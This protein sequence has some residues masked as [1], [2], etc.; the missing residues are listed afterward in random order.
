MPQLDCDVHNLASGAPIADAEFILTGRPVTAAEGD[1]AYIGFIG[2]QGRLDSDGEAVLDV[3]ASPDGAWLVFRVPALGADFEFRMPDHDTTLSAAWLAYDPA[4]RTQYE[5]GPEGPPGPQGP[6]PP[7]IVQGAQYSDTEPAAPTDATYT[8]NAGRVVSIDR[9]TGWGDPTGTIPGDT[10]HDLWLYEAVVNP[11]A[12]DGLHTLTTGPVI[13][14]TGTGGTGPAGPKGDK[15]DKGDA[16]TRGSLW[17]FGEPPFDVPGALMLDKLLQPTNGDVYSYDGSAWNRIG[18]IRGPVGPPPALSDV[19]PHAPGNANPGTSTEAARGDHRHPTPA[20]YPWARITG[21]PTIPDTSTLTAAVMRNTDAIT[22]ITASNWVTNARLSEML[23]QA[24]GRIPTVGAGSSQYWGTDAARQNL[25][26]HDLPAGGGP[27]TDLTGLEAAT[28]DLRPLD[29]YNALVDA[30]ILLT[31]NS[32][33][34]PSADA[35]LGS[36]GPDAQ[37]TTDGTLRAWLK[38]PQRVKDSDLLL[39]VY[40]HTGDDTDLFSGSDIAVQTRGPTVTGFR[41]LVVDVGNVTGIVDVQLQSAATRYLG[42]ASGVIDG[43]LQGRIVELDNLAF[44]LPSSAATVQ[45]SDTID[46]AS[47]Q[48]NDRISLKPPR[49]INSLYSADDNGDIIEARLDEIV[50]EDNR[51]LNE[52]HYAFKSAGHDLKTADGTRYDFADAAVTG[53]DAARPGWVWNADHNEF[54]WNGVAPTVP[55]WGSTEVEMYV[56]VTIHY[57]GSGRRGGAQ[58]GSLSL[59]ASGI[60]GAG[61][62]ATFQLSQTDQTLRHR[63]TWT[64]SS[65]PNTNWFLYIVFG[66]TGASSFYRADI[67]FSSPFLGKVPT[68][69]FNRIDPFEH[70]RDQLAFSADPGDSTVPAGSGVQIARPPELD[71]RFGNIFMRATEDLTGVLLSVHRDRGGAIGLVPAGKINLWTKLDGQLRPHIIHSIDIAAAAAYATSY[72]AVDVKAGQDFWWAFEGAGGGS[73]NLHPIWTWDASRA[74]GETQGVPHILVPGLL[75]RHEVSGLPEQSASNSTRTLITGS[76]PAVPLDLI[77]SVTVNL[78]TGGTAAN[79]TSTQIFTLPVTDL[80]LW[81]RGVTTSVHRIRVGGNNRDFTFAVS[82]AGDLTVR[83]SNSVQLHGAW[84]NHTA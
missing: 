70:Y 54:R 17:F 12:G 34:P 19:N 81:I 58:V 62:G 2:V 14:F 44:D 46:V 80:A 57:D 29:S 3:P 41:F 30:Q 13:E 24:V 72:R 77:K 56:D 22:A 32:A 73:Q 1:V 5:R 42:T 31:V 55:N 6:E 48:G 49:W 50:S 67:E 47:S 84:I 68:A 71:S 8:V 74:A 9:G 23:Q 18:T 64:S 4:A 33:T 38:V 51:T 21:K 75:Q 43:D 11:S 69:T 79:P 16:G 7:Y 76:A 20:S 35:Y 10:S 52:L 45:G 40:K 83:P 66:A 15:G 63:F 60:P 37:S 27:P 28:R 65:V 61:L 39:H 25:G 53:Y 59:H 82:Q 26:W 36:R 78:L